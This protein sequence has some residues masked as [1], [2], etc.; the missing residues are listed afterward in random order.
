MR[1]WLSHDFIENCHR[2]PQKHAFFYYKKQFLQ[3]LHRWISAFCT[4]IDLVVGKSQNPTEPQEITQPNL[5]KL[6]D[7]YDYR[8]RVLAPLPI[9]TLV[10]LT[11]SSL[12]IIIIIIIRS[13]I[14]SPPFRVGRHIVFARVVCLSVCPSVCHKI[15]SAL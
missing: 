2:F 13:I 9:R 1:E 15:V 10:L 12:I 11:S 5:R 14:M 8:Y 3:K 7:N 4:H 6:T